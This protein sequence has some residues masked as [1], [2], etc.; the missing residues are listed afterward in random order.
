MKILFNSLIFQRFLKNT[1]NL[2]EVHQRGFLVSLF[3]CIL[4]PVFGRNT[5]KSVVFIHNSCKGADCLSFSSAITSAF[6]ST[7]VSTIFSSVAVSVIIFCSA[8]ASG[9]GVISTALGLK[10]EPPHELFE[11]DLQPLPPHELEPQLFPQPLHP[12]LLVLPPVVPQVVPHV[13]P[14]VV[15][16]LPPPV[17]AGGAT[18]VKSMMAI[19]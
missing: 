19:S 16:P 5:G 10:N 13:F 8:I 9:R 6:S 4:A 11:E 2:S 7:I 15:P 14:P 3:Y 17:V 18:A 12:P 1:K